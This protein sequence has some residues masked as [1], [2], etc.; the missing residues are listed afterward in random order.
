MILPLFLILIVFPKK[1]K[2]G[3]KEIRRKGM[4]NVR[5]PCGRRVSE[6]VSAARPCSQDLHLKTQ[7]PHHSE[8][9]V[10]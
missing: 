5:K 4:E 8:E 10:E 9:E 2:N 6:N 1:S 3:P 7:L